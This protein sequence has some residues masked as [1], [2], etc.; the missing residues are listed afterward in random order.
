MWA[1]LLKVDGEFD[2]HSF[3][4]TYF[5]NFALLSAITRMDK[6][7]TEQEDPLQNISR[8]SP[9]TVRVVDA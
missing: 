4:E 2:A 5:E 7:I 6:V 1:K 3:V 8:K 9:C